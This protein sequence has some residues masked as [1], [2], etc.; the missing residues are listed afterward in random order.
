MKNSY[1]KIIIN[2]CNEQETIYTYLKRNGYSENYTKKLRKVFGYILLNN[3]EVF[4]TEH[5]KNNDIL[6]IHTNPQTKTCIQSCIIPLEIVYEDKDILIINKPSNL[7]CMPTK[8]HYNYNLAGAIIN[9]M[10]DKDPNFVCRIVNRLDKDTAGLVIV[11]KN[12][13]VC[14]FL[15]RP[16]N[17]FKTYYALCKGIINKPITVDKKIFTLKDENNITI[18]KRETDVSLGKCAVT[19]IFPIQTYKYYSLIKLTL[20]HGRTHQ[21]RTHLASINHSLLGDSVYGKTTTL[22]DHTALVCKCITFVHP[23]TKQLTTIE[24]D[25]P[26]DFKK[27]IRY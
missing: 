15:S 21:I 24:I 18:Q 5:I 17:T 25:F 23:E 9:Y 3:R 27:L 8:S 10:Q 20:E 26:D 14:N 16:E 6:E 19:H 22:I 2:N 11:A 1:K 7:A 12:S 4:I 13:L